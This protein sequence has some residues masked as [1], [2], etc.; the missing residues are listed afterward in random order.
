MSIDQLDRKPIRVAVADNARIHAQLLADAL[1]RD[2]QLEVIAAIS[3]ARE[4][5]EL[6][7]TAEIDVAVIG[8]NLDEQPLHGIEVLAEL[9]AARPAIRPIVL[10]DSSKREVVLQ[11][12]RA[13]ARGLFS[14]H[15]ALETLSKCVRRVH[16]GQIWA[17]T[18]QVGFAIDALLASPTV[19]AVGADGMNLL[20]KRELEVVRCLAEGLSNREIAERLGLSQHTVK[21]YLFRVFDKLGVSSRLE[22]LFLTLTQPHAAAPAS[23]VNRGFLDLGDEENP[24]ISRYLHAAERGVPSAQVALAWMYW[25]GKGVTKDPVAAYM[26]YLIAE[27]T[28]S[29]LGE[30]VS[31]AKRKLGDLMDS[32]QIIEAQAKAA[33]KLKKGKAAAKAGSAAASG[34]SFRPSPARGFQPN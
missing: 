4:L 1:K 14:R 8:C 30:E 5:V 15:E 26:W 13:G 27:R 7:A 33:E 10:L 2:P 9:K 6:A 21:N 20:S 12:F 11:A 18:E 25:Q 34:G 17:S 16:E 29:E 32:A 23:V 3:H 31:A 22:L 19:R 28:S 24:S